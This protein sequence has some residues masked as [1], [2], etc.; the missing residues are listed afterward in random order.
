VTAPAGLQGRLVGLACVLGGAFVILAARAVDL[1]VVRGAEFAKR[2]ANQHQRRVTLRGQ[3]GSILDRN[4]TLLASSVDVP[5]LFVNGR[6][7]PDEPETATTLARV[8]ALD[9]AGVRRKLQGT[10]SFVWLKRQASP[11]EAEAAMALGVPGLGQLTEPRRFYPDGSLAAHVLGF[12]GIDSQGQAGLEQAL[13]DE[14]RGEERDVLVER[15]A[16]GRAIASAGLGTPL[17]AGNGVELTIDARIQAVVERELAAGVRTAKAVAGVAIVGDPHTGEILALANVPTF[18]P[19]TDLGT[20]GDSWQKRTLNRAI[21]TPYEPGSTL[22]AVFA[23]S[24]LEEGAVTPAEHFFCENGRYRFGKWWIRDSH[25]HGWL[26]FTE[27]IRYSSNICTAKVAARVGAERYYHHLRAFG[28]GERTGIE[29][30]GE[31]RGILRPV[32]SWATVD[33]ATHSF[34]QGIAVTPLQMVAAFGAIANGGTLMRSYVVRRIVGSDGRVVRAN[35]PVAVRRVLGERAAALTTELLRGVVEEEGGT[36]R[37][38]RLEGV[39]VA[40]K[41]GTAQKSREDGRGYS[42]KRVASFIGFVPSDRPRAVILV[43]VDEPGTTSYGGVVAA[44]VFRAIAGE[45]LDLL[46]VPL[47]RDVPLLPSAPPEPRR[48]ARPE[49]PVLPVGEGHVPRLVGLSV[50]EAL[51]RAQAQ[52]W[53]VRV[54]GWGYVASQRPSPGVPAPEDRRLVLTLHAD[55][56]RS[57]P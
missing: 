31:S 2:A 49:A 1:T 40:G 51:T 19:N 7:A 26:S 52:R 50:R 14:L 32:E 53:D 11:K 17:M 4:G 25:P 33:L 47:Q 15:D 27:V 34:G 42:S 18:D 28:F 38:A 35:E 21:F 10:Q 48:A 36:G 43:L 45:V 13:D 12:V 22:K 29:V 23:A 54:E 20:R 46:D 16:H 39:H 24:A 56:E 8:L 41:T 5:S 44:P 9:P 3:R 30:P 37:Q 6:V 55:G 57:R